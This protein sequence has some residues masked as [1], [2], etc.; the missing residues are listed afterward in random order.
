LIPVN[1]DEFYAWLV[2]YNNE[3]SLISVYS[4]T[5]QGEYEMVKIGFV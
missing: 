1:F 4:G 3:E 5:V 2:H